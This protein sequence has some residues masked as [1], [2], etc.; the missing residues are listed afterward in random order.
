MAIKPCQGD[1]GLV[2][3]GKY[4]LN[5]TIH[6]CEVIDEIFELKVIFPDEYPLS[7]PKVYEVGGKLP[8][9]M[10]FH[11]N[12]SDESL[13]LG[14]GLRVMSNIRRN[15]D[16]SAF[17]ESL[18]APFLYSIRYK[19]KH[20]KT[21]YGELKH[22]EN[23]L[24]QDYEEIFNLKGKKAI[25]GILLALSKRKRVANKLSCPCNCKRRLGKCDF[26]FKVIEWRSLAKRSWFKQHLTEDFKQIEKKRPKE[27][28]YSKIKK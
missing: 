24:I 28:K 21:P 10:D 17:F 20:G 23:G 1:D 8:N 2:L 6:G 27:R 14:S 5:A 18:V 3:A 9:D 19:T 16:I 13:C 4:R 22:G 7:P 15:P 25:L 26:R 11:K 12:S